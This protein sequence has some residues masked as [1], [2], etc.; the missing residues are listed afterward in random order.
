MVVRHII[1]NFLISVFLPACHAD[2]CRGFDC[3]RDYIDKPEPAYKWADTGVR[4]RD[5]GWTGYLLNFTSQTW[6]GP[7]AVTRSEWWHQ[8]LIIVPDRLQVLDTAA[9]WV[10]YG[11]NS[12]ADNDNIT[13]ERY[14]VKFMADMSVTQGMVSA[15]VYQVPNQPVLFSE[16]VEQKERIEN[17]LIAFTW[18]HFIHDADQNAEYLIR[19]PMVKS[20]VKAMDT[21][22]NFLTDHTGPGE[23]QGLGLNPTKFIA[24]GASKRGWTV[25]NLATVDSRVIAIFPVIMDL[26]NYNKNMKNQFASYGG[27]TWTLSDFWKL[28]ITSYTD[29]KEMADMQA[30]LDVYEYPE[31]MMIPK[32]LILATNDEFFLPTNTRNWWKDL[33][34]EQELNR[35]LMVPNQDHITF[36]GLQA[37]SQTVN[38]WINQILKYN[39]DLTLAESSKD[40]HNKRFDNLNLPRFNWTHETGKIIVTSEQVPSEVK[41]WSAIS[42]NDRRQ[43]W[44]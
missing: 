6:L 41:I 25:W 2:S 30:I 4:L 13:P 29:S 20:V 39:S 36:W 18:W 11:D 21:V 32:L 5:E 27:W 42:C 33:P 16:D 1:I 38:G 44:R 28:N 3:M 17:A 19:L 12:K 9:L 8:L 24:G 7:G 40:C 23:I 37:K 22:T 10:E 35:L 26:L 15:L 43:D 34:E 31:R 14:N